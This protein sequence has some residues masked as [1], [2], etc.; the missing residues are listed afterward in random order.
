[1]T[2]TN[3]PLSSLHVLMWS[4]GPPASPGEVEMALEMLLLE[5]R[6]W[7]G[8]GGC[9]CWRRRR[10]TSWREIES[11]SLLQPP[12]EGNSAVVVISQKV[13]LSLPLFI[14]LSL[15]FSPS[16]NLFPALSPSRFCGIHVHQLL[17]LLL[18][19]RTPFSQ[20][21]LHFRLAVPSSCAGVHSVR[22][23]VRASN[24][25]MRT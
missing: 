16:L 2:L 19:L 7:W 20:V 9:Y 3:E 14:C 10:R 8:W 18:L 25:R 24:S 5:E 12:T 11:P 17:L 15:S 22:A 13:S 21:L 6:R 4:C 23:C 1:M